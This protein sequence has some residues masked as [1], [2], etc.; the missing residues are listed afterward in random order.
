MHV[1]YHKNNVSKLPDILLINSGIYF[2][3]LGL[4]YCMSDFKLNAYKLTSYYVN[5]EYPLKQLKTYYNRVAKFTQK[6]L[7]SGKT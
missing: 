7:L 1:L 3:P 5:R 2:D 4:V 6:E